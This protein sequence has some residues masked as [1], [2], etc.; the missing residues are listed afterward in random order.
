MRPRKKSHIE[1]E[2]FE[3]GSGSSGRRTGSR[4]NSRSKKFRPSNF[5]NEKNWK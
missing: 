5:G 4:N 1:I 3:D 2:D